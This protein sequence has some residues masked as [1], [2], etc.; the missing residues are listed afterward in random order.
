MKMLQWTIEHEIAQKG[1][2]NICGVDENDF[3]DGMHLKDSGFEKVFKNK[4]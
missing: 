3:F 2:K 4:F 1:Y